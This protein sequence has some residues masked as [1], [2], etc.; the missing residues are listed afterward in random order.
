[1]EPAEFRKFVRF[2]I[3]EICRRVQKLDSAPGKTALLKLLVPD[4]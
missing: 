3:E 2:A 4:Y 1:M